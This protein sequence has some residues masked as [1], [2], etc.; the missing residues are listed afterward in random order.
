MI[1]LG[2]DPGP[3]YTAFARY[4]AKNKKI[5]DSEILDNDSMITFGP[6]DTSNTRYVFSHFISFPL[7]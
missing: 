3:A 2:I 5:I 6:F 1:I 4:D 7:L